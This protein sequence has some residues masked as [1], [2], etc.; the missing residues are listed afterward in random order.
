MRGQRLN[1]FEVQTL[2]TGI[3]TLVE[4]QLVAGNRD[5]MGEAF[6]LYGIIT[7]GDQISSSNDTVLS[8]SDSAGTPSGARTQDTP[9]STR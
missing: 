3:E 4:R 5:G 9:S 1:D 7:A 8:N 6:M 2:P